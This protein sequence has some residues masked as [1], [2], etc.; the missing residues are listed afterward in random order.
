MR[1]PL[2]QCHTWILKE[3]NVLLKNS[4]VFLYA[5]LFS[6]R[7]LIFCL[8][9]SSF[10]PVSF[11]WAN[12]ICW[13]GVG[14]FVLSNEELPDSTGA[15]ESA[16]YVG[17]FGCWRTARMLSRTVMDGYSWGLQAG[18]THLNCQ[19]Q[20]QQQGKPATRQRKGLMLSYFFPP[21]QKGCCILEFSH[22]LFL[23]RKVWVLVGF[24]GETELASFS[25]Q[26]SGG[27]LESLGPWDAQ[28]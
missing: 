15:A 7:C 22:V 3:K 10:P 6:L 1:L 14:G 26:I 25:F 5:S 11:L 17:C 8:Q 12:L 24:T 19:C 4:S 18:P 21:R 13:G 2:V 27:F 28:L 9:T 23:Q 16:K 20:E